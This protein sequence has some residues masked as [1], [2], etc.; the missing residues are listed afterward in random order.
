MRFCPY[1]QRT[2][3]AL[4]AKGLDYVNINC[5]LMS[6]PDWLW[7]YNPIGKVPV[8][9]HEGRVLYESVVTCDYID[10]VFPGVQLNNQNPG[11]AAEERML[12]E[13]L[14][15]RMVLP[16]MKIWFGFKRGDGPEQRSKH[17]L[18]AL[19]GID[20]V[21]ARLAKLKT[22]FFSG[23][24]HPGMLDYFLWPWFERVHMY[25]LVF[26]EEALRFP[27]SR[28][29][30]L[31]TWIHRM[32]EDKTVAPYLLDTDTHAAFLH[33]VQSGNPNYNMLLDSTHNTAS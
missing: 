33:T 26:E 8:L 24:A 29:P 19:E 5:Q 2:V 22:T 31:A 20:F 12:L 23:L 18:Q 16:Q 4:E 1:A 13:L 10:Q 9:F 7:D 32:S 6:K 3:L 14:S 11:D 27:E 28:F 25:S 17:W 21:E 30:N 15:S